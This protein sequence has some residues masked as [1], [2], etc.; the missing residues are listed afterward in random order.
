MGFFLV[1]ASGAQLAASKPTLYF[2]RAVHALHIHI[3][4]VYRESYIGYIHTF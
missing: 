4:H 3:S 1:H 2:E